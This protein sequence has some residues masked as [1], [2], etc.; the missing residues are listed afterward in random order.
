MRRGEVITVWLVWD[1]CV[2]VVGLEW[3]CCGTV[4]GLV[5]D[6]R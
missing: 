4:V 3:D 1:C 5:L 2:T 6:E